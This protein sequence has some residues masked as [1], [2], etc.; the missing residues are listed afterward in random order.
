LATFRP[1]VEI[2]IRV[3][4]C[5]LNGHFGRAAH[6]L[7]ERPSKF[8]LQIIAIDMGMNPFVQAIEMVTHR[9]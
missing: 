2:Q 5:D 3:D 1:F 4:S 9:R 8:L 7:S 6:D